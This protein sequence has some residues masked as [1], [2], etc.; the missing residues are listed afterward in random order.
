MKK[1][2]VLDG[3]TEAQLKYILI[4]SALQD[5]A[6]TLPTV[7]EN[8]G[9][10]KPSACRMIYQLKDMGV[11]KIDET[12]QSK[13]FFLTELGNSVAA[14]LEHQKYMIYRLLTQTLGTSTEIAQ[15]QT[16]RLIGKI[17]PEVVTLM[18]MKFNGFHEEE[19]CKEN[20][21][22]TEWEDNPT[23]G[24]YFIPFKILKA[25]SD[26]ISMGNKGFEHPCI[27]V[28]NN[29]KQE[30]I[31]KAKDIFYKSI[32]GK[33]L[34]GKL[35]AMKYKNRESGVF[36]EVEC[37]NSTYK[38]PLNEMQCNYDAQGR[39]VTGV[40][41]IM[42]QATVGVFHMSEAEADLVLN[43]TSVEINSK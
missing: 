34:Y 14:V 17:E 16:E 24:S 12:W 5:S 32:L 42:V 21:Y 30:V 27:L 8:M 20:H 19:C 35:C 2:T 18:E 7:A 13:R 43:L 38:L 9:V 10:K 25:D 15:R 36:Q 31:L 33:C 41:R 39:V 29:D 28:F 23:E 11:L 37:V 3:F 1:G 40:I 4:I 22:D 26:M 6:A